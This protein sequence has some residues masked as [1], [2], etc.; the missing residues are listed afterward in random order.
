MGVLGLRIDVCTFEG[1]KKGVLPIVEALRRRRLRAT[2]FPTIGPDRSGRA[3]L[4]IFRKKGFLS[5]M[6]RT[7]A[8]SLYGWRTLL[9]GT[10]LPAPRIGQRLGDVLRRTA[11]EGHEVGVHAWDHV[12]WQDSLD[13]LPE[14]VL[15]DDYAQAVEAFEKVVGRPP[16]STAAPAWITSEAGLLQA[17]RF[18]FR[19]ASDTRGTGPFR[20]ILRGKSS[21]VPQVPITLPTL[22]EVL[23]RDGATAETF[24]SQVFN[25]LRPDGANVLCV[26][27]ESEGRAYLGVFESFLERC[28]SLGWEIVPLE[29]LLSRQKGELPGL[30][31]VRGDVPGRAGQVSIQGVALDRQAH[32]QP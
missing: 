9:H 25:S 19:Y 23:G 32:G 21:T 1:L 20:P 26:H 5:K 14:S 16:E 18:G 11:G 17:E 13:H 8:V 15:H 29:E 7:R 4:R 6:V 30:P 27:A 24:S 3:V 31:V 22:D 2:F 10:L 28:L 12:R